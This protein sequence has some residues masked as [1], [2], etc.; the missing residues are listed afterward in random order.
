MRARESA[1]RGRGR[2]NKSI[3]HL[4]SRL[5]VCNNRT[6]SYSSLKL[7]TQRD[8]EPGVGHKIKN[9]SSGASIPGKKSLNI[10]TRNDMLK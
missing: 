5:R 1:L 10:G 6:N 4:F 8:V 2:T 3:Y 7:Y 9:I